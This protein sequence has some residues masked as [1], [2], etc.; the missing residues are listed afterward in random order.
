MEMRKPFAYFDN[1]DTFK[2]KKVSGAATN[3]MY[4][5]FANDETLT[6]GT[7]DILFDT[8]CFINNEQKIFTHGTF[9]NCE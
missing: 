7:P 9:Y 3:D 2:K 8:I 6:F 1:I 4:I 5:D